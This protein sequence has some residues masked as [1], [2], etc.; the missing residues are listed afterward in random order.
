MIFTEL[1]S[2][3]DKDLADLIRTSLKAYQLDIPGTVYYD[4][5]LDHLSAYYGKADGQYHVLLEKD[6]LIGGI[7]LE[8][9]R[10][11]DNCC[12]LQ[13]LYLS[14]EY[15]GQGLGYR[16]IAFLEDR[17]RELGYD[18]VYLETHSNLKPA[19]HI[20]EKSGYREIERPAAVVHSSMDRF[21]LKQIKQ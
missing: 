7:G 1:T 16:M 20:Y 6:R 19:I 11:F 9:F 18:Q 5:G 3:Y 2:R 14:E 4:E 21:F 13:K 15:K 17:A 8:R 12:E 10:T